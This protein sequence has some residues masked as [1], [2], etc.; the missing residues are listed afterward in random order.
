MVLRFGTA[1][2]VAQDMERYRRMTDTDCRD[3][4][5]IRSTNSPERM[6]IHAHRAGEFCRTWDALTIG[7]GLRTDM[8]TMS[9]W[10]LMWGTPRSLVDVSNAI[11]KGGSLT[12]RKPA[13]PARSWLRSGALQL[14][15]AGSVRSLRLISER[16][17]PFVRGLGVSRSLTRD[18]ADPPRLS[19]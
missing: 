4:R 10:N 6:A 17:L 11:E 1:T 2:D 14:S 12:S 5:I 16:S 19:L 8:P 9:E 3:G 15:A 7:E 13:R 18:G